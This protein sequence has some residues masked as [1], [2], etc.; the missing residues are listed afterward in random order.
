MDGTL[1]EAWASEELSSKM[2]AVTMMTARTATARSART[3]PCQYQRRGQQAIPQSRRAEASCYI[4][5]RHGEPAWLAVAAGLARQWYRRTPSLGDMLRRTQAACHRITAARTRPRYR[6]PRGQP[7]R[8]Q[9]DADVTKTCLTKTGRTAG[10]I[11]ERTTRH[12]GYGM[13]QSRRAM[14]SASSV[15]A[16][17]TAP[18]AR[19]T[20]QIC[21]AMI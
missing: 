13:S 20:S 21:C 7:S 18:C 12:P 9:R 3:H 6:R 15:G 5:T 10:A 1:I 17:S 4:A 14:A 2:A 11:D 8:H 19:Q 16:S